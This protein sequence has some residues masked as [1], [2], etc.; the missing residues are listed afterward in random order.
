MIQ[1]GGRLRREIIATTGQ[2]VDKELGSKPLVQSAAVHIANVSNCRTLEHT[3]TY[4]VTCTT[5]P[6]NA[7]KKKKHTYGQQR[8]PRRHFSWGEGGGAKWCALYVHYHYFIII[9]SLLLLLL[10]RKKYFP[11]E[12]LWCIKGQK[13]G[14]GAWKVTI[15]HQQQQK[16][17]RTWN[18]I[19]I[20]LKKWQSTTQR[21]L[22]D[23]RATTQHLCFVF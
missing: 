1:L 20:Y 2:Q 23:K 12:I 8:L 21:P 11:T 22:G 18:V 9:L 6:T 19:K 15:Y 4:S 13:I 5:S 3:R 17:K 14:R 16:Q 10:N 7:L